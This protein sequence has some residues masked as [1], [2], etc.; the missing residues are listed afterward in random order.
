MAA[1][2]GLFVIRVPTRQYFWELY[3]GI[4]VYSDSGMIEEMA[5]IRDLFL[6]KHRM[7]KDREFR[8]CAYVHN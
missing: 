3:Q 4:L 2:Q 6:G 5:S 1:K 8:T 7:D